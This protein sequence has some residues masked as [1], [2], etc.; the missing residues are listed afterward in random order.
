MTESWH[1]GDW[2][3]T[4]SGKH[5]YPLSPDPDAVD[6]FDIAHALG[7]LCRYGGHVRE[8]YSVAEHCVHMARWAM[9]EG[10]GR[11]VALWALLHDATEAYV[12]DM[13]RPLKRSMPAYVE[14]ETG[15]MAAILE[16]FGLAHER[17]VDG[18]GRVVRVVG[19][20]TMVKHA[21]TRI[22]LTER[23][24]LMRENP[25]TWG[26]DQLTPLPVPI[27]CWEPKLATDEY[28]TILSEL[29]AL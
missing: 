4:F 28:L 21:D 15:V 9:A 7:M 22:L 17:I 3:Q 23:Q 25:G 12:G 27:G 5:F 2:M 8:F 19:E 16:R 1:R 14:L 6:P 11:D 29:G 18:A 20:P 26:V 13:I 10:L 24:A